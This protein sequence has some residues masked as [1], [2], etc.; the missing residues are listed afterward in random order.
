MNL[1]T[2]TYCLPEK[3]ETVVQAAQHYQIPKIQGRIFQDIFGLKELA[4]DR[5]ISIETLIFSAVEACLS[6]AKINPSQIKWLIHAHTGSHIF[7]FGENIIKNI[8][9]QFKFFKALGFGMSL[10]KCGSVFTALQIINELLS[11]LADDQLILL[12]SADLAFTK[13]LQFI[14]ETTITTDGATAIL[15]AKNGFTNH[16]LAIEVSVDGYYAGGIWADPKTNQHFTNNYSANLTKIILKAIH[17][18]GL[19]IKEIKLIFPHNVNLFSWKQVCKLL[20]I[21]INTIFWENIAKTGHC[22]GIDP[23]MNY[24]DAQKKGLINSGDYLVFATAGLGA[25]FAAMVIQA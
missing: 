13:I 5:Q 2:I 18:V 12:I 19:N 24:C 23:F 1:K 16:V 25:T 21:E 9:Y 4:I 22:F 7:P 8:Q 10:N 11:N 15:V 6:K 3:R 20:K 14:P 17:R